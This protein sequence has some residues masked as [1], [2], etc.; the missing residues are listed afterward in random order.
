MQAPEQIFILIIQLKKKDF[1]C[2]TKIDSDQDRKKTNPGNSGVC[3]FT[4]ELFSATSFS[5]SGEVEYNT[6]LKKAFQ[7][8]QEYYLLQQ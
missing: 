1:C 2:A 7:D 6:R 5:L 4:E 8:E 3:F